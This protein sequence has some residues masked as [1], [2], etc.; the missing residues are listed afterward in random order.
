M[1]TKMRQMFNT[2]FNSKEV[3]KIAREVGAVKRLR[4]IVPKDFATALVNCAM[5][6]ETRSIATARRAYSV[7]SGYT[8]EES[9]FYDRFNA[10]SV[11][12]M[13]RLFEIALKSTTKQHREALSAALVGSSL[14]DIEAVETEAGLLC[15][16]L[17]L[18]S[19]RLHVSLMGA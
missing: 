6:D 14:V 15:P 12:L 13:K 9:S 1:L 5:G 8:P 7:V 19:F 4:N 17:L 2:I 16:L 11:A 3:L 18:I 10:G